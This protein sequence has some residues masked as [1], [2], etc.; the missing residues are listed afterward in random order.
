MKIIEAVEPEAEFLSLAA[1]VQRTGVSL[2]AVYRMIEHGEVR[3]V[4]LGRRRL[5][6]VSE[7]A[8][9]NSAAG[10]YVKRSKSKKSG[11]R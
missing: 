8:R 6:P 3:N 1:F 11:R 10:A 2:R 4:R 5:I 9:L 7:L